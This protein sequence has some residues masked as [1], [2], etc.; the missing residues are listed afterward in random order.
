[1]WAQ[2]KKRFTP[3][4]SLAGLKG[5][6]SPNGAAQTSQ[7]WEKW[8]RN[9]QHLMKSP[10]LSAKYK[11]K[12]AKNIIKGLI[13]PI[14]RA[15][16]PQLVIDCPLT[17]GVA[18]VA[19]CFWEIRT[20]PPH[21]DLAATMGAFDSKTEL[22]AATERR[23]AK[24]VFHWSSQ[25]ESY[26]VTFCCAMRAQRS[27]EDGVG[28]GQW[29]GGGDS[30]NK[31]NPAAV[32]E[33]MNESTLAGMLKAAVNATAWAVGGAAAPLPDTT[34]PPWSQERLP[35]WPVTRSTM[36]QQEISSNGLKE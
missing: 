8:P 17:V 23:A 2:A 21:I 31:L 7:N 13:R 32:S 1:M 9:H 24:E 4:E 5:G 29:A 30:H 18:L 22:W 19:N 10:A 34:R 27:G 36:W 35:E 26:K 3:F 11:N 16:G 20:L 25:L 14:R 12:C 6:P 28:W 33:S 15:A